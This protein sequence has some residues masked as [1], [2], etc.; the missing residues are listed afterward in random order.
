MGGIMDFLFYM[1]C[2]LVGYLVGTINPAY[3]ISKIRGFDIRKKGSGNAGASNA[4]IVMGKMIG[5]IC[6]LFDIFKATLIIWLMG[7]IFPTLDYS[8]AA[9]GVACIVGH[10]FPFYMKFRGGKGLACLGGMVLAFD[11]RVFLLM[12]AGELIVVFLTNYI[13]FVPVTAGLIFPIV[14]GFMRRDLWGALI[15]LLAGLLIVYRHKEN[16]KRIRNGSEARFSYLWNKDKE[17]ERLQK[18]L[19]KKQPKS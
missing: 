7:W 14:Y 11:W 18:N 1:I 16:F 17:I 6:A 2:I 10:I 9:V 5:V 13:C 12:L 15:L 19:E 4:V 8:F 3:I